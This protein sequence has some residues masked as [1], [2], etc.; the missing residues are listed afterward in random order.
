MYVHFALV[1]WSMSKVFR[2][3]V[4]ILINIYMIDIVY[5]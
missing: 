5:K 3:L 2:N 4:F 1:L